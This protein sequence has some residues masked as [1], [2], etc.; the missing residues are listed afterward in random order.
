MSINITNSCNMK[1]K[2]MKEKQS[3]NPLRGKVL[4]KQAQE[5]FVRQNI[6]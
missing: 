5:V 6:S 3:R 4:K 1:L 2:D